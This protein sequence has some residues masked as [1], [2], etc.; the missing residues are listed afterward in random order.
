MLVSASRRLKD[1]ANESNPLGMVANDGNDMDID[2][3]DGVIWDFVVLL[4]KYDLMF[5]EVKASPTETVMAITQRANKN[6]SKYDIISHQKVVE[7]VSTERKCGSFLL[8]V[9][10][11]L[12]Y[13]EFGGGEREWERG[14]AKY[15]RELD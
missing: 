2:D 9:S 5:P 13:F 14:G 3:L 8:D 11:S 12:S 10:I 7:N 1:D 15:P 4:V 6:D